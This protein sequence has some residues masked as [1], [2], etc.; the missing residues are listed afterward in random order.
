MLLRAALNLPLAPAVVAP[1]VAKLTQYAPSALVSKTASCKLI[2]ARFVRCRLVLVGVQD[3]Y[4]RVASE[5]LRACA[6]LVPTINKGLVEINKDAQAV[7]VFV[8]LFARLSLSLSR[9][10]ARSSIRFCRRRRVRK[11]ASS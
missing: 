3:A 6:A 4:F 9:S 10:L 2:L 8:L 7:R 1:R 5:A 11:R